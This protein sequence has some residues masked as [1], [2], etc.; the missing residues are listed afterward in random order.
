[1]KITDPYLLDAS[2]A[3]AVASVIAQAHGVSASVSIGGEPLR[4]RW[5]GRGGPSARLAYDLAL[6]AVAGPVEGQC[7]VCGVLL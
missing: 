4:F 1:M 5:D 6:A 2:N 7:P 3:L